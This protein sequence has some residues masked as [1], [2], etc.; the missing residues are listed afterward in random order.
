MKRDYALG[1]RIK[2]AMKAAGFATAGEFCKKHNVPYLTFA[3]HI[4]G[5]RNPA[6]DFLKLYSKT[7]GVKAQWIET[8]EGHPLNN[9]KQSKNKKIKEV[10]SHE[11]NK[12]QTDVI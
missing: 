3:Q 8:G 10:F 4:Q 7:F 9:H 2:A 6:P 5:R 12:F 11:M 1:A